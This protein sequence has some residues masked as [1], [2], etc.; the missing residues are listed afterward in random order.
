M[1]AQKTT[2]NTEAT[3]AATA[4]AAA[5][6]GVAAFAKI[7]GG[8]ADRIV[9]LNEAVVEAAKRTGTIT[10]DA[11]ESGLADLLAIEERIGAA[12]RLDWVGTLTKAHTSYVKDFSSAA[13]ALAREAMK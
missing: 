6:D 11:Y 8:N 3:A 1:T 7:A 13:T 5:A 4:T 9:A 10:L 2:P 12:T